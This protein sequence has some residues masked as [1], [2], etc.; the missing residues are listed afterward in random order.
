MDMLE[1][2]KIREK[3]NSLDELPESYHPNMASKWSL[4]EAGLDGN[5]N[6][7]IIAWKRIAVA[8]VLLMIAGSAFVLFNYK[9]TS[10]LSEKSTVIKNASTLSEANVP[11]ASTSLSMTEQ[12][13]V[14][15]IKGNL[16]PIKKINEKKLLPVPAKEED[17]IAVIPVKDSIV[18]PL[19]P[20]KE[21]GMLTANAPKA[22]KRRFIE[23]DFND[24][25][26][27][28]KPVEP[29]TASHKFSFRIGTDKASG[30]EDNAG[31]LTIRLPGF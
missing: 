16:R 15:E 21:T 31:G 10:Q 30:S 22:K 1:N 3:I 26:C 24:E 28:D 7:R 13:L 17:R 19:A 25:V 2:K 8:A 9:Q 14:L 12:Q 29:V 4:L 11:N 27:M 23:L 6:K 18:Q 20:V 5:D